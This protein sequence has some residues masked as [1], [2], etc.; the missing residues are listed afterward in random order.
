MLSDR[1]LNSDGRL[2][3]KRLNDRKLSARAPG[4]PEMIP[5]TLLG[6]MVK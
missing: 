1:R 3:E 6:K 2:N 5:I 4:A